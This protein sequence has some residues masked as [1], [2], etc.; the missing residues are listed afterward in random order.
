MSNI[1]PV[2]AGKKFP[3]FFIQFLL[4]LIAKEDILKLY[5][6]HDTLIIIGDTGSGKTTRKRPIFKNCHS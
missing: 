6:K 1:L 5:E 3:A 4:F 2:A